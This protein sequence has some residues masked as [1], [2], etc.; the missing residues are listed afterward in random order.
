M[1]ETRILFELITL[2]CQ[3]CSMASFCLKTSLRPSVGK[4][5]LYDRRAIVSLGRHT[6]KNATF[7]SFFNQFTLFHVIPIAACSRICNFFI[8]EIEKFFSFS[9]CT[10]MCK[11]VHLRL[12]DRKHPS[13]GEKSGSVNPL[14]QRVIL[15]LVF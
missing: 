14:D 6:E 5:S 9:V 3:K 12:E 15:I 2:I 7:C 10:F 4:Y 13:H 11:S 1:F 8:L